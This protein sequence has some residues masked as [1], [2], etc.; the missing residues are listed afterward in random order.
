MNH[1]MI[2]EAMNGAAQDLRAQCT[3]WKVL[4]QHDP[5]LRSPKSP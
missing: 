1:D 3:L 4:Y 5:G 2:R